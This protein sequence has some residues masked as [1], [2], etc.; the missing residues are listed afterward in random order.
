MGCFLR[1]QSRAHTKH[2]L[3]R[4]RPNDGL[5]GHLDSKM[6]A[7]MNPHRLGQLMDSVAVQV[8]GLVKWQWKH[9]KRKGGPTA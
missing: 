3:A 6:R 4:Q 9:V 8:L 7:L 2:T 1:T 5:E